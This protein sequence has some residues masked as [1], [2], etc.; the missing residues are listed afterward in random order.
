[1]SPFLGEFLH[2]IT[3]CTVYA[4][5]TL[6]SGYSIPYTIVFFTVYRKSW[7][8]IYVCWLST[9]IKEIRGSVKFILRSSW[10]S[11]FLYYM[12]QQ[13][14][15]PHKHWL[16]TVCYLEQKLGFSK[17]SVDAQK[18]FPLYILSRFKAIMKS[19]MLIYSITNGFSNV[20]TSTLLSFHM[21]IHNT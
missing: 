9:T 5:C 13:M 6:Y 21:K 14:H 4:T 16:P 1:M 18:H 7:A 2:V 19:C 8:Y 11:Q 10:C 3:S 20:K 12:K 17:N 15:W